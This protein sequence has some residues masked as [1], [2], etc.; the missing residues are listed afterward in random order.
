MRR[1]LRTLPLLLYRSDDRTTFLRLQR[2]S[3]AALG[4]RL[5][6]YELTAARPR[7][8]VGRVMGAGGGVRVGGRRFT[9]YGGGEA[10]RPGT[11]AR[12]A[13]VMLRNENE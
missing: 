12:H 6:L 10:S 8:C 7:G 1:R 13:V 4:A 11:V 5:I 3:N 2:Q 9:A